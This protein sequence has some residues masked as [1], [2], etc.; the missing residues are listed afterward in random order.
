MKVYQ[1]NLLQLEN[2]LDT[3]VANGISLEQA[4]KRHVVSQTRWN[5]GA[6]ISELIIKKISTPTIITLLFL[7]LG[8]LA[9]ALGKQQFSLLYFTLFLVGCSFIYLA[10]SIT[11][12]LLLYKRKIQFQN[13]E[14]RCRVL[15]EGTVCSVSSAD[16]VVGDVVLLK[17]GDIVSAD[18]RIVECRSL[19]VDESH[20]TN[21]SARRVYKSAEIIEGD[22]HEISELHNMVFKGSVVIEGEATAVITAV[23]ENTQQE[24]LSAAH[25][26][27]ISVEG[28]YHHQVR[29]LERYVTVVGGVLSAFLLVL[30]WLQSGL[31]S[32]LLGVSTLFLVLPLWLDVLPDIAFLVGMKRLKKE[33]VIIGDPLV[34][35]RLSTV[36][37]IFTHKTGVLTEND[38]TVTYL[39][40]QNG[41][42][43]ATE[44]SV[45]SSVLLLAGADSV[46]QPTRNLLDLAIL[47][48]CE[49]HGVTESEL[50]AEYPSV[51]TM[52]F[53]TRHKIS[54]SAHMHG[55]DTI[56]IVKGSPDQIIQKCVDTELLNEAR[57]KCNEMDLSGIKIVAVAKRNL[58]QIPVGL[59]S[60][61]QQNM[62][63]V[64]LIFLSDPISSKTRER[65]MLCSAAG[66]KTVLLSNDRVSSAS[67]VAQMLGVTSLEDAL[68]L[69]SDF[70]RMDEIERKTKFEKSYALVDFSARQK[71]SALEISNALGNVS[72]FIANDSSDADALKKCDVGFASMDASDICVSNADVLVRKLSFHSVETALCI[73]RG[74]FQNLQ[75]LITYVL[76]ANSAFAALFAFRLFF[77]KGILEQPLSYVFLF[78]ILFPI[79]VFSLSLE[80]FR[81]GLMHHAPRLKKKSIFSKLMFY[82]VLLQGLLLSVLALVVGFWGFKNSS[83]AMHTMTNL[84]F[85]IGLVSSCISLRS[86]HP[87]K[88]VGCFSNRLMPFCAAICL[89]FF[90]FCLF[91][92]NLMGFFGFVYLPISFYIVC[93]LAGILPLIVSEVYKIA[94]T[95][96]KKRRIK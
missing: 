70:D 31:L 39:Y 22:N 30:A 19:V 43:D 45:M 21:E 41:F 34:L 33:G 3:D 54:S 87:L 73:G 12:K 15:R 53:E 18:A 17:S 25:P 35:E 75:K 11:T 36:D 5:V 95:M 26:R 60:D 46:C 7:A 77:W 82:K 6:Y 76:I 94:C 71:E 56:L 57:K 29:Q 42:H 74:L 16:L 78:V 52:A 20:L 49:T 38:L 89:V 65:V 44:N 50:L 61:M 58:T 8:F 37:R 81:D 62:D 72:A 47:R 84:T 1:M 68:L 32:A 4:E 80:P 92:P 67:S 10:V 24:I 69:S 23:G 51:G 88:Q 83:G 40:D 91:N 96:L 59:S 28:T 79:M 55:E 66:V 9:I 85:C 86:N 13:T 90:S 93:V 2:H 14:K 48:A 63:F 27:K 64:G